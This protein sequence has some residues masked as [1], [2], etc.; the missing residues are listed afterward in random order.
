MDDTH[1]PIELAP[2]QDMRPQGG[3]AADRGP[4]HE[5]S[6]VSVR[7]IFLFAAGLAVMAV[8]LHVV[9][10]MV[11]QG[12]DT[13]AGRL[14]ARRPVRYQD[15]SGQFPTPNLQESPNADMRA[16]AVQERDALLGYG[17][18]DRPAGIA[19]IPIERAMNLVADQKGL[20]KW[21]AAAKDDVKKD[22]VKK[23][24][25]KKDDDTKKREPA[26]K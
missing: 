24:E 26:S 6:D 7:G 15:Q 19:R 13:R 10:G 17:W 14:E 21:D 3:P 8:V 16:M 22:D 9:L 23:D 5:I 20:M 4:G 2:G 18:V 12:F 1:P 11:M 25:V